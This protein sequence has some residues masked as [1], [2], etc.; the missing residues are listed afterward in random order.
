MC[1]FVSEN[2]VHFISVYFVQYSE[3]SSLPIGD[4]RWECIQSIDT[5][6]A[7]NQGMTN[8][9]V[10]VDGISVYDGPES[11]AYAIYGDYSSHG[12]PVRAKR[13][14]RA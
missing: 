12:D 1:Y 13:V 9:I 7:S 6:F 8:N 10:R 3:C 11:D 2:E 14:K 5:T 4:E